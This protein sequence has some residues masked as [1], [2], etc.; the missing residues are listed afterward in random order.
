[1]NQKSKNLYILSLVIIAICVI[2]FLPLYFWAPPEMNKMVIATG[3]GVILGWGTAI[4]TFYFG[5]SEGSRDKDE[6]NRKS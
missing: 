3:I 6:K 1:M 5:S 4:V 2:A